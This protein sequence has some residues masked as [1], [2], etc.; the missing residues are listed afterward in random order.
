MR[1][2]ARRVSEGVREGRIVREKKYTGLQRARRFPS[3]VAAGIPNE[4]AN[5]GR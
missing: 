2:Y 3:R 5:V 4:R 1:R